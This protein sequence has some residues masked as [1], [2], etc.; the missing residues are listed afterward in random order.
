MEAVFAFARS[1]AQVKPSVIVIDLDR[2]KQVNDSVGMPPAIHLESLLIA[3]R[4]RPALATKD[5]LA[6]CPVISSP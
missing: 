6:R 3:R 2:F 4:A 1:D 5:T